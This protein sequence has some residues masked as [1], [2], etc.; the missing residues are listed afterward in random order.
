MPDGQEIRLDT[1][2]QLGRRPRPPRIQ[3]SVPVRLVT[4]ASPTS[5]V[6]GTHL[7]IGQEGESVVVTDLG[8]TN[9]TIVTAP[10]GRGQRLRPGESL[11]ALPGT[12]V[13]IGDGNIIEILPASGITPTQ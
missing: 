7:E 10:R 12:K 13:D 3:R 8:S 9:G 4:V 1:V 11:V 5:A 6:S 2:C